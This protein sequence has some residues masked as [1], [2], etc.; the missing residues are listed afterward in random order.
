MI[1]RFYWGEMRPVDRFMLE[2]DIMQ[3]WQVVDDLNL[4]YD[5]FEKLTIDEFANWTLGLK[6]MQQKRMD[7]V[8]N[9]FEELIQ[10]YDFVPRNMEEEEDEPEMEYEEDEAIQYDEK[11]GMWVVK[12]DDSIAYT[13]S[14]DRA[15]QIYNTLNEVKNDE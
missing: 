14:L 9:T 2:D 7:R 6:E 8:F 1:K 11:W 13:D 4:L 10:N 12:V 15:R 3:A 5:N